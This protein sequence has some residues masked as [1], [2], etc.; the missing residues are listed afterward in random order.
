M[1]SCRWGLVLKVDTAFSDL[2]PSFVTLKFILFTSPTFILLKFSVDLKLKAK[3]ELTLDHLTLINLFKI[4]SGE[5]S[6]I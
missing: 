5:F 3:F 6:A 1:Y 2:F 4:L